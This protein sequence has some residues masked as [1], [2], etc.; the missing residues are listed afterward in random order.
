MVD[1][2]SALARRLIITIGAAERLYFVFE[3]W[4]LLLE[5]SVC[6]GGEANCHLTHELY[7]FLKII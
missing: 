6:V 1:C 7:I 3:P 5:S 4:H 2:G